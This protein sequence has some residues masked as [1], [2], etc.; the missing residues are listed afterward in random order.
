MLDLLKSKKFQAAIAGVVVVIGQDVLGIDLDPASITAV[1]S[2][3]VSYILGQGIADHGK[4]AAKV[5]NG[6]G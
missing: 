5:K 4:E 2:L 1:I 3:I 6:S